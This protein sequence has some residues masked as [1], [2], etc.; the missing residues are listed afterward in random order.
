MN[1]VYQLFHSISCHVSHISA[2]SKAIDNSKRLHVVPANTTFADQQVDIAKLLMTQ[3]KINTAQDDVGSPFRIDTLDVAFVSSWPRPSNEYMVSNVSEMKVV[4]MSRNQVLRAGYRRDC[5]NGPMRVCLSYLIAGMFASAFTDGKRSPLIVDSIPVINRKK[6]STSDDFCAD[7]GHVNIE[8]AMPLTMELM[9]YILR[10]YG[11]I[12]SEGSDVLKGWMHC[13]REEGHFVM[14]LEDDDLKRIDPEYDINRSKEAC[15]FMF[16]AMLICHCV[17][18]R[19]IVL[20]HC[21]QISSS[22]GGVSK[23][24]YVFSL[25]KVYVNLPIYIHCS[26]IKHPPS[27]QSSN[28][29]IAQM[30]EFILQGMWCDKQQH[31]SCHR[32]GETVATLQGLTWEV[33]P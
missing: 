19:T 30:V 29:S 12:F 3:R 27:R 21:V 16:N 23:S 2:A 15:E 31:F 24:A 11:K 7:N 6:G 10:N 8:P 14:T 4:D 17:T 25:V 18:K 1:L 13:I 9:K 5:P 28:L 33:C 32:I 22:I 26:A 20:Y